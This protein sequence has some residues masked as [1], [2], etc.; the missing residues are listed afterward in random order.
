MIPKD[1]Y[2]KSVTQIKVDVEQKIHKRL[3]PMEHPSLGRETPTP[4][5]VAILGV[6]LIGG[7]LGLAIRDPDRTSRVSGRH[8]VV[9]FD[10][11][12]TMQRAMELGAIDVG[13]QSA[14]DAVAEAD[15]VFLAAPISANL[16]LMTEIADALSETA[17]VTDVSSVKVASEAHAA[18]VLPETVA[19]IGGHP[20]AGSEKTGVEHADRYLFEN[21]T[22]V[23]CPPLPARHH[24]SRFEPLI[25]LLRDLGARL[26]MMPSAQHDRIAA[27]ISHLPQLLAVALSGF[28][29]TE[30]EADDRV[31]K[32]AAGGFRDMT[33]IASSPFDLWNEI[34]L[35]NHGPV[36]DALA[37]FSAQFQRIRN[38]LIEEGM[39]ELRAEFDAARSFR[40]S[41]PLSSKGFLRPLSDVYIGAADRPGAL[42]SITTVLYTN[43]LNIKDIELLKLREGT[44]GTFRVGFD[45]DGDADRAVEV[46]LKDGHRAHRL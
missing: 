27:T 42:H 12:E 36:L 8:T 43:H 4:V 17:I 45:T 23:L 18:D 11:R 25:Q 22:Y 10:D 35:A 5:R 38:R 24:P 31:H 40:E 1:L 46:L 19:Y 30:N 26:L 33:R 15:I 21:A 14:P 2:G 16:S 6:G 37:G 7:S 29:A 32:L 41:V 39:Q 13:S 34:L 44:G 20:M 3:V 9:G 28:A